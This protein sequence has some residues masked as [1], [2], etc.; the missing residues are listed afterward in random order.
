MT[1]LNRPSTENNKRSIFY[2]DDSVSINSGLLLCLATFCRV[3]RFSYPQSLGN[4]WWF[5]MV[6]SWRHEC[7]RYFFFFKIFQ[8][9][10]S[11]NTIE[12]TKSSTTIWKSMNNLTTKWLLSVPV[13]VELIC[14]I[15]YW[16]GHKNSYQSEILTFH[17]WIFMAEAKKKWQK[18][19]NMSRTNYLKFTARSRTRSR[20]QIG[21]LLTSTLD[22]LWSYSSIYIQLLAC[23]SVRLGS[24]RLD[25][26]QFAWINDNRS[27]NNNKIFIHV[28]FETFNSQNETQIRSNM[29]AR[30]R[31][32]GGEHKKRKEH[33]WPTDFSIL[34]I[35]MQFLS[36]HCRIKRNTV[37]C[38]NGKQ[39]KNEHRQNTYT[40]IQ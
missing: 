16:N 25:W 17:F 14:S 37:N 21:H 31:D 26:A 22:A 34:R 10:I 32:G 24:T 5:F 19:T 1:N 3:L 29:G 39:E 40:R 8:R 9:N 36:L 28:T 33:D 30:E 18:Q 27:N 20:K 35:D 12:M 11:C 38:K 6:F 7:R 2:N 15:F 23:G 13:L 4:N